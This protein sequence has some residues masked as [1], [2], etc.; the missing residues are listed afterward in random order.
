MASI[1]LKKFHW[2]L[3]EQKPEIKEIKANA[4][5]DRDGD[6]WWV[7]FNFPQLQRSTGGDGGGGGWEAACLAQSADKIN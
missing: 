6:G 3:S 7:I 2:P 5:G 1:C 4:G